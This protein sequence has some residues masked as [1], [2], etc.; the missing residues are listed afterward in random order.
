MHHMTKRKIFLILI[1]SVGSLLFGI[2]LYAQNDSIDNPASNDS[3]EAA[4][5]PP[6]IEQLNAAINECSDI[7]SNW[8]CF[9]QFEAEVDP[10]KFRFHALRDRRPLPVMNWMNTN[11][12]G[13]V[14]LNLDT[15]GEQ[16]PIFVLMF[17]DA[18]LQ[19]NAEQTDFL[20]RIDDTRQVC[21]QTPPG[22]LIQ[23]KRGYRDTLT[24]N[25]VT[26]ELGS[27]AFVTMDRNLMTVANLRDEVALLIDGE[28]YPI[29][30]NGHFLVDVSLNPPQIVDERFPSPFAESELFTWAARSP[31]RLADLD[32]SNEDANSTKACVAE[33]EF[34]KPIIETI[35]NPGH[36][37]LFSVCADPGDTISVN[38][39]TISGGLDPWVDLRLPNGR[40]YTFNND[41]GEG[42]T[43]SI[44]CNIEL[45]PVQEVDSCYLLVARAHR[46]ASEGEFELTLN[47]ETSCSTP[48]PRC[49]VMTHRSLNLRSGPGI[50]FP[51]AAATPLPP[52]THLEPLGSDENG[53]IRVRVLSSN[54]VGYVSNDPRFLLCEEGTTAT[55]TVTPMLSAVAE[56]VTPTATPTPPAIATLTATTTPTVATIT[57]TATPTGCIYSLYNLPSADRDCNPTPTGTD[58]P[59]TSVPSTSTPMPPTKAPAHPPI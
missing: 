9:G 25:G 36:E 11:A 51:L 43:D 13:A 16:T 28:R 48:E 38:L 7:N 21:E 49:E 56:T 19:P 3:E 31:G 23:T 45:P 46:N 8:S 24:L 10:I 20:F 41:I 14:L 5:C 54:L 2:T 37:C 50:G 55:P 40:L 4:A 35:N 34:G 30:E 27:T 18:Y 15:Q 12:D 44:L 52:D 17:G 1:V 26:I 6:V 29:P 42:N 57:V 53:W 59:P 33:L 47:K 39:N 22:M 58:D 32:N